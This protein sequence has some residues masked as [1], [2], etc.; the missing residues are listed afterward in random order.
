MDGADQALFAY[1]DILFR[2]SAVEQLLAADQ[3]D[4][5]IVVDQAWKA[6]YE[7]RLQNPPSAG[8]GALF[9]DKQKLQEI[10]LGYLTP[11]RDSHGS[12]E[13]IG[14]GKLTRHRSR[15]FWNVFDEIE[16]R[17]SPGAPFQRASSGHK[18]YVSDLLQE[19]VDRGTAVHCV[20]I[21][22][23]WFEVDT[24]EDYE[25]AQAFRFSGG[26]A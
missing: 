20:P 23:G 21:Q 6:R 2:Q 17:L 15:L 4:I 25:S 10:G 12:G 24:V 22:G 1:A 18:A 26:P 11:E 14:M 3:S 13:F 9:D 5:V 7:G 19:L 16:A 8:K